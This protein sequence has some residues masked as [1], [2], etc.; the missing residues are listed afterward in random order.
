[1]K[2]T[3][4]FNLPEPFVEALGL[5]DYERGD[6]DFTTTELIKP[7]RINAYTKEHW[8]ELVEDISE[9][10]WAFAGQTKHVVLERIARTNPDR[11]LVEERFTA[12]TPGGKKISGKIDLFDFS[13][14]T[15]YDWKEQSVW[16]FIMGDIKEW[17]EQANINL[18]L[19]RMAQ[20]EVHALK[21]VTWLKDW[22]KRLARTTKRD[23]Y[24]Q[25]PI[26]V[27]DLPMWSIGQQQ[28]YILERIKAQEEGRSDPPL[29]T[30]EER[31]QRDHVFALH[32]KGR[33]SALRLYDNSDQAEAALR[34]ESVRLPHAQFYIEERPAEPVRCLDFCPVARFCDFGIE[35]QKKWRDAN[36]RE[37]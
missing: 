18:F 25:C 12:T 5:D 6:A 34:Q 15:L 32:K 29:C 31:W 21:V 9:R 8:D 2:L 35:A 3:N 22:K 7:V 10:V 36:G 1:M 37:E 27:I 30:K 17:E 33:K 23:D 24:P 11:Y 16:K 28:E 19:M 26:H 20:M 13:D 14:G 4:K